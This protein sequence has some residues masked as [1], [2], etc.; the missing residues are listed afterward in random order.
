M[1]AIKER[2][3]IGVQFESVARGAVCGC[4]NLKED[5]F[6]HLLSTEGVAQWLRALAESLASVT[7][8]YVR[9][10]RLSLILLRGI[11]RQYPKLN[12]VVAY[13]TCWPT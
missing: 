4:E 7:S 11:F 9:G 2:K 13:L 12:S 6:L 5:T 8:T 3:R 10:L 1:L